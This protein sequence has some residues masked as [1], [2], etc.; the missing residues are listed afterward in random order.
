[1]NNSDEYKNYDHIHWSIVND[2][3]IDEYM[4]TT[5]NLNDSSKNK[6]KVHLLGRSRNGFHHVLYGPIS[7]KEYWK[8]KDKK[9]SELIK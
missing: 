7:K 8:V 5:T 1:M 4:G 9:Y 3:P 2:N 6:G